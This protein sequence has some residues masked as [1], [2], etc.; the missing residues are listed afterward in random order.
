MAETRGLVQ[1]LKVSTGG[2][3][4]AYVGATANNTAAFF[5]QRTSGDTREQAS[6]KDDIVSALAA[7]QAAYREVVVVHGDGASE[8]TTLRIEPV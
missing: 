5:V 4:Y 1:R 6:M 8:I 2:V 3:T 7:A